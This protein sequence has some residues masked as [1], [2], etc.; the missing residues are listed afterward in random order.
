MAYITQKCLTILKINFS[1]VSPV[2]AKPHFKKSE[3][4]GVHLKGGVVSAS[5][6][7]WGVI[8]GIRRQTPHEGNHQIKNNLEEKIVW[9]KIRI[10]YGNGF[11]DC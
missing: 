4:H 7:G 3:M 2:F 8:Q 11:Q 5:S 9:K 10:A 1:C 6:A